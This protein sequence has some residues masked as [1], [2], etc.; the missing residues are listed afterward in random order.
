MQ[1]CI[2]LVLLS[3]M[4][5]SAQEVAGRDTIG[6]LRLYDSLRLSARRIEMTPGICQAADSTRQRARDLNR[7]ILLPSVG[8]AGLVAL[9]RVAIRPASLNRVDM[10]RR[11]TVVNG[12]SIGIM[13]CE[14]GYLIYM[15]H[16]Q[17]VLEQTARSIYDRHL[18][19]SFTIVL[20]E[21]ALPSDPDSLVA[22][23]SAAWRIYLSRSLR[24]GDT[25]YPH[26]RHP[27]ASRLNGVPID[28]SIGSARKI[29]RI[30]APF[31]PEASAEF[32]RTAACAV[33]SK[34][35]LLAGSHAVYLGALGWV[36]WFAA[37]WGETSP[38]AFSTT[39]AA[40]IPIG[41]GMDLISIP[42]ARRAPKHFERGLSLHDTAL[43]DRYL[44]GSD[45]RD[46]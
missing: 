28:C 32:R 23:S 19:D 17:K 26:W 37:S 7:A 41:L 15:D 20:P 42:L 27:T 22:G 10:D 31:S 30:V 21:G 44:R 14:L 9:S 25:V 5:G 33:S 36:A 2:S 40:M 8:A 16:R 3:A 43:R 4:G 24:V 38:D 46:E 11:K 12:I 18:R 6:A 1:I 13:A 39:M 34:I 29:G 35:L 45:N